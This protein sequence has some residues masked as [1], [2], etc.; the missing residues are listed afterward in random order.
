MRI[1]VR[2]MRSFFGL[3][4]ALAVSAPLSSAQDDVYA[5]Y[6]RFH[7]GDVQGAR[8]DLEA[9]LEKS[10]GRLP[11]RFAL[12]EI[13]NHQVDGNRALEPEFEKQMDAFIGDAEARYGRSEKDDEA[14]FYAGNGYL[15]RAAYRVDHDK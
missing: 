14:L 9:L 8:R 13:L 2:G 11:V 6:Q 1:T 5:G 3:I 4:L 7:R 10:P 12:L 15:L